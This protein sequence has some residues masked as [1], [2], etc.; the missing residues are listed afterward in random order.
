MGDRPDFQDIQYA[1]AAHIRDPANVPAP[2]NIED[3]RMAVYRDLFFNN[4]KSLLSTTYPVLKAVH[5]DERWRRLIR[6]FMKKH[7]AQTPYFLKLPAEFLD[8]LQHE[9]DAGDDDFPFLLEL[10]HYEYAELELSIA[11]IENDFET[12]EPDGDCLAGVPVKSELS[13]L[14]A[15]HFPV[16]R[17]SSDFIPEEPLQ[18]PVY[19]AITRNAAGK[20]RFTELNPVSAGL[21]ARIEDN[22]DNRSGEQLLRE[23]AVE[24]GFADGDAFVEHGKNAFAELR[25]AE[26]II[27]VRSPN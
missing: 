21:L 19:L 12:I 15:Y 11:D 22:S 1:F 25:E 5:G 8:F 24:I 6:E 27:G 7:S 13:W 14:F 23:L 16:H 4:L 2:A 18:Q 10:A 3:R 26:I 9:Y 20:V 17:I